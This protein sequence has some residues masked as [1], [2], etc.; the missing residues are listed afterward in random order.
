MYLFEKDCKF[1]LSLSVLAA[2]T[3]TVISCLR[4]GFSW[5][6]FCPPIYVP[7]PLLLV[8]TACC[9]LLLLDLSHNCLPSC[10]KVWQVQQAAGVR[11]CSYIGVGVAN[12]AMPVKCYT[13]RT[14]PR[15]RVGQ[16]FFFSSEY[17]FLMHMLFACKLEVAQ[18]VLVLL[19]I[20]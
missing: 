6:S 10:V 4:M 11:P 5:I 1:Q 9:A 17:H 15:L 16:Q 20:V 18:G 13:A 8:Q 2:Y 14:C 12:R 19:F 7:V 3:G